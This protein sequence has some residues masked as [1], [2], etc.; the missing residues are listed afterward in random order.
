MT[1]FCNAYSLRTQ[2]R[3]LYKPFKS[4][5]PRLRVLTQS[6]KCHT[7]KQSDQIKKKNE[8][9]TVVTHWLHIVPT[10]NQLRNAECVYWMFFL[11]LIASTQDCS[12]GSWDKHL[13]WRLLYVFSEWWRHWTTSQH[14]AKFSIFST[15]NFPHIHLTWYAWKFIVH[16][17]G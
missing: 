1:A 8:K 10:V 4:D 2:A 6:A 11:F 17:I 3:A 5:A 12:R 16:F 9:A 14:L 7:W 15:I 13:I